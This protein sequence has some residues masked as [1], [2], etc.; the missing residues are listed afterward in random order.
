N[1]RRVPPVPRELDLRRGGIGLLVAGRP[2]GAHDLPQL[3]PIQQQA[4]RP[5]LIEPPLKQLVA[6]PA[7]PE[8]VAGRGDVAI[9]CQVHAVDQF[10]HRAMP[11]VSRS[12]TTF[13]DLLSTT[14]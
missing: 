8:V 14:S 2:V 1:L 9:Q 5:L 12:R 3:A 13:F 10:P 4:D 7:P 11:Y 6:R